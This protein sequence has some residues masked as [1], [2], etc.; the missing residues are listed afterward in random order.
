MSELL[1]VAARLDPE[2]TKALAKA[3]KRPPPGLAFGFHLSD[4]RLD[5]KGEEI[6]GKRVGKH[7]HTGLPGS[8]K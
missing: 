6:Y 2:Y 1:P 3:L 7:K 5:A 4:E 8:S